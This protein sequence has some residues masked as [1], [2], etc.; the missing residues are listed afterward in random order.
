MTEYSLLNEEAHSYIGDAYLSSQPR[1]LYFPLGKSPEGVPLFDRQGDRPSHSPTLFFFIRM[2]FF[3]ARLNI[4]IFPPILGCKYS[5][6]I[7]NNSL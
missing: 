4:L 6:I 2:L 3:R 5:C 1:P 7:L